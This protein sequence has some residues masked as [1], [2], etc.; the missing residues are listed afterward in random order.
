MLHGKHLINGSK[1]LVIVFQNAAKPLNDA[2]PDIYSGKVTQEEV[3]E[4]H[5]RYTWMKFAERVP[6]ADYFFVKDHFS[7]VYGWYFMD[8]GTFIH[9]AFNEALTTFIKQHGYKRVIAFGS[10]KGGTGA[11]LYGVMNPLITDVLSLIPQIH[12]GRFINR[13]CPDEKALFYGNTPGFEKQV[14]EFLFADKLYAGYKNTKLYLYSGIFDIQFEALLRYQTFLTKKGIA[15]ELLLN[16][17]DE[18]HTRLVNQYTTFIY[19]ALEDLI[20]Q[21]ENRMD[22]QAIKIAPSV[23]VLKEQ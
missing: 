16:R 13:L 19:G 21:S 15:S 6:K 17:S 7:S 4:M 9:E 2:I 3:A 1:T 22:Q 5:E 23:R 18:R 10:S 11:L 8:H 12:V 14:D 20:D